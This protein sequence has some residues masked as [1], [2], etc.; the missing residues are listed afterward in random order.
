MDDSADVRV[1]ES[2]RDG[3]S[4]TDYF[5]DASE[6]VLRGCLAFD[7][8]HGVVRTQSAL[9][10]GIDMDDVGMMKPCDCL[11]LVLEVPALGH[12]VNDLHRDLAREG[13]LL[14]EVHGSHSA[15]S[16]KTLDAEVSAG[17]IGRSFVH[18]ESAAH[19]VEFGREALQG[20]RKHDTSLS[21][22]SRR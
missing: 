17:E 8:L 5:L 15:A 13:N 7:E 3:D 10:R 11:R 12:A 22:A 1:R 18:G 4:E 6:L 20:F 19:R 14:G 9:P 21:F 16:D 2:V